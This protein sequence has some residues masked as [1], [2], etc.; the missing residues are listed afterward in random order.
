MPSLADDDDRQSIVIGLE[1]HDVCRFGASL[2][3]CPATK[4]E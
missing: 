1:A 4:I 3:L 2:F